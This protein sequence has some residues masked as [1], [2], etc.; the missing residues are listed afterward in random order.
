MAPK[1]KTGQFPR[2][3]TRASGFQDPQLED[4]DDQAV[5]SD[6]ESDQE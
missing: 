3:I 6:E 5:Y 2:R 4:R 1:K